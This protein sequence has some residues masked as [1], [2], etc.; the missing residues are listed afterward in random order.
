MRHQVSTSKNAIFF[1]FLVVLADL[2]D[3]ED[4]VSVADVADAAGGGGGGQLE[5]APCRHLSSCIIFLLPKGR[6]DKKATT[7]IPRL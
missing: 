1:S 4:R 6:E 2:R 7:G 3:D 5:L